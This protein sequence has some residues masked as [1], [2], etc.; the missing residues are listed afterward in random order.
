MTKTGQK[1]S[2]LLAVELKL[3]EWR[4]ISCQQRVPT[5]DLDAIPEPEAEDDFGCS[6]E[7]FCWIG[8]N[9]NVG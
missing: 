7:G 1:S 9:E 6:S 2:H 3:E 4:L 8:A 5:N